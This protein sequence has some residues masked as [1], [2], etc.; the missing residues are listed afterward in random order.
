MNKPELLA[1]AGDRERLQAAVRYGADAVYLGSTRLGMRSA[2]QN[3]DGE[4]LT[5]AVDFCHQNGVRVYL[6]ANVLAHNR[7]LIDADRFFITA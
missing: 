4:A 7:D 6:T 1:P 2:P 3:F 5:Q